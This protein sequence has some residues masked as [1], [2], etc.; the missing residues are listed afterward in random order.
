MKSQTFFAFILS[1]VINSHVNGTETLFGRRY[2][3]DD[4][5]CTAQQYL[6]V[7]SISHCS[8]ACTQEAS[9]VGFFFK[10]TSMECLWTSVVHTDPAAC[11]T[12]TNTLYY[13]EG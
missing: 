6:G 4:L 11:Q 5:I 7:E 12:S 9:C 2:G 13:V 10:S 3:F 8:A 1:F